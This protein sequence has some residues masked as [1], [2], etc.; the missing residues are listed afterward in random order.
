MAKTRGSGSPESP[1]AGEVW[2]HTSPLLGYITDPVQRPL[3]LTA[4]GPGEKGRAS[5]TVKVG[6]PLAGMQGSRPMEDPCPAGVTFRGPLQG[7]PS[8][9]VYGVNA[10]TL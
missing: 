7:F 8:H 2:P 3:R 10:T 4:L 5:G 6:A 9:Q 1:Q